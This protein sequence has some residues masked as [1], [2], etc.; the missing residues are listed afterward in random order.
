MSV[1]SDRPPELTDADARTRGRRM[2]ARLT[3][4][5]FA[6]A[7]FVWFAV[8]TLVAFGI[9]RMGSIEPRTLRLMIVLMYGGALVL[10]ALGWRVLRG[11]RFTDGL[12]LAVAGTNVLVTFTDDVGIW[13][14]VYLAGSVVLLVVL[15]LA[16]RADRAARRSGVPGEG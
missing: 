2:L 5:L 3:R 8:A 12:A 1:S 9:A 6:A 16:Q 11:D 14:A 10:A 7:A 4:T 15:V 13:D